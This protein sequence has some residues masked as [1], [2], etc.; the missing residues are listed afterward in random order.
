MSLP[1]FATVQGEEAIFGTDPA[2][3]T[4]AA[5]GPRDSPPPPAA[6]AAGGWWI[7]GPGLYIGRVGGGGRR[8]RSGGGAAGAVFGVGV[9]SSGEAAPSGAASPRTTCGSTGPGAALVFFVFLP[10]S[11]WRRIWRVDPGA[12]QARWLP[13]ASTMVTAAAKRRGRAG[14]TSAPLVQRPKFRPARRRLTAASFKGAKYAQALERRWSPVFVF[15]VDGVAA[16]LG[17]SSGS[18][19]S[20][21]CAFSVLVLCTGYVDLR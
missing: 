3:S 11:R 16:V 14:G 5:A 7:P 17:S 13:S 19:S 1:L 9:G 8:R 21:F 18:S 12:G 10:D 6:S 15:F 4:R 20:S 2:R